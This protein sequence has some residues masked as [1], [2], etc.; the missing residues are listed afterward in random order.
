MIA[1]PFDPNAFWHHWLISCLIVWLAFCSLRY[2]VFVL[3]VKE[4]ACVKGK[5]LSLEYSKGSINK[6][7]SDTLKVAY[8]YNFEGHEYENNMLSPIEYFFPYTLPT[9]RK[10]VNH[11]RRKYIDSE[12]VIV[13]FVK[14]NPQIS[15][16]NVEKQ[17]SR[18]IL[19]LSFILALLTVLFVVS[20]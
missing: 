1:F 3:S 19:A 15:Y 2:L 12:E 5:V 13:Y 4:F 20:N 10:V 18:L 16:L 9:E 8:S 11:I 17:Y 7:R 14:G 6:E